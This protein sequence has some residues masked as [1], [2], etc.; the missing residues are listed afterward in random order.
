MV[1]RCFS[2]SAASRTSRS[3]LLTSSSGSSSERR[4][5]RRRPNRRGRSCRPLLRPS[6]KRPPLRPPRRSSAPH[7]RRLQSQWR[8][9]QP[10]VSFYVGPATFAQVTFVWTAT[11]FPSGAT[12]FATVGLNATLGVTILRMSCRV[13]HFLCKCVSLFSVSWSL[14]PSYFKKIPNQNR[15]DLFA[16][17]TKS[18]RPLVDKVGS[19]MQLNNIINP[20]NKRIKHHIFW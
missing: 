17:V 15:K 12:T 11:N 6:S 7:H 18:S 2:T 19:S 4:L 13:S 8:F 14:Y 9:R 16:A 10:R 5:R 3:F 1:N 20:T